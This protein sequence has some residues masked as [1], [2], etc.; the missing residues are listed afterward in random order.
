MQRFFLVLLCPFLWA[1]L[2]V[3]S[4]WASLHGENTLTLLL[5]GT[6]VSM[7]FWVYRL[8][9]GWDE[10]KDLPLHGWRVLG[11]IALIGAFLSPVFEALALR[12]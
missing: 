9:L 11:A 3:G 6:L 8:W 5:W 2:I 12:H 10:I 4:K 7:P 1:L